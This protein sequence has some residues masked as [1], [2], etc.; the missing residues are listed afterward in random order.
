VSRYAVLLLV[1]AACGP[2]PGVYRDMPATNK[3][4]A[5]RVAATP[6]PEQ[7]PVKYVEH[8]RTMKCT[9]P[10]GEVVAESDVINHPVWSDKTVEW[11]SSDRQW[12]MVTIPPALCVLH[13]I[14]RDVMPEDP[15]Q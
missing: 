14:E 1:L 2:P 4:G 13:R 10:S 9:A 8:V 3:R 15:D 12:F 7:Q 6:A 11:E 5:P